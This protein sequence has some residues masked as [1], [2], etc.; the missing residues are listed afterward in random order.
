M[1]KTPN[2]FATEIG[3]RTPNTSIDGSPH[4]RYTE[5]LI[6]KRYAIALLDIERRTANSETLMK[7]LDALQIPCINYGY[8][9]AVA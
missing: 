4:Q 2:G 6:K 5:R 1:P 3:E 9:F 7:L 8:I